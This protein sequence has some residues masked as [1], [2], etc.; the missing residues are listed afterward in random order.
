MSN[1][2]QRIEQLTPAQRELF[3]KRLAEKSSGIQEPIAVVGM[4]CR[5]PDADNV[6]QFWD[7]ICRGDHAVRE[8]PDDRFPVDK[9]YDPDYEV[10]G[11]VVS[12]W[13]C[14]RDDLGQFDPQFFGIAPREA[15]GMDPQQR[16]LLEVAWE[17]ME[18]ARI[19]PEELSK[20]PT[21]VFMGVSQVDYIKLASQF[22]N[23][24]DRIDAHTG[25]G[26]SL[27]ICAN[28]L[29]YAFNFSGPSAAIDTAC[30]SAMVALHQAV[31]SLRSKE[32][33][34]ALVGAANVC[35]TPDTMISLSRARMVSPTGQCRPFHE[36]ANGYVR[37]EG[38]GVV[39]LKRL[40]DAIEAGDRVLAILRHTAVNH[41]GRTSGITAPS[42]TAQQTVIQAALAGGGVAASDIDYIEAHGTGTPLGDPIEVEALGQV[43]RKRTPNDRPVYLTSVKANIGHLE[44]AAGI[45]GLIKT[46]LVLRSGT[47]PLQPNLDKLNPRIRTEGTRIQ[48]PTETVQVK[49][50]RTRRLAGV[51][52]F[53]FGGTNGHA[54]VESMTESEDSSTPV[55]SPSQTD[56]EPNRDQH[57]LTLSAKS[58]KSLKRLAASYCEHIRSANLEASG[59]RHLG[60]FCHA[61]AVSRT[62]HDRRATV[63]VQNREQLIAD[64]SKIAEGQ[65]GPNIHKGRVQFLGRGRYGFLFTG[66]GSQL[67]GMGRE[68]Y[69]AEPV[70]RETADRCEAVFQA[71]R[72]QSLL[73]VMF[74]QD[75]GS[76][77]DD[78]AIT[79]PAL[80]TLEISLAMLWKSWGIT[81]AVVL[82]HSVGEYAAA[83]LAGVFSIEDGLRLIAKRGELMGRLPS[84]G[85]MAVAFTDSDTATRLFT[86]LDGSIEIA[87]HNGPQNTT[88]SG[89]ADSIDAFVQRCNDDGISCQRL[90]VSHAFHSYRMDPMLHEFES[91][92]LDIDFAMP[93]IPLISN[94]T[95]EQVNEKV[96]TPTYWS[97]QIRSSVQFESGVATMAGEDL[98]AI[99]EM[100]P[101]PALVGMA[102]RCQPDWSV[103]AIASLRKGKPEI[104][105]LLDAVA[106]L[107]VAGGTLDWKAFDAA[108]N[109]KKIDL[110]IYPFDHQNYWLDD[111]GLTNE[112]LDDVYQR[113]IVHPLLGKSITVAESTVFQCRMTAVSHSSVTDHV[114]QGST[115]VPGSGYTEMGFAAANAL[116]GKGRHHVEDLTFQHALFLG[117]EAKTVQTIIS[118][119]NGTRYPFRIYSRPASAETGV[120]WELNATGTIVRGNDSETGNNEEPPQIDL[121]KVRRRKVRGRDH[122]EFYLIMAE[123][124][125]NYGPTYQ[126]MDGLTQTQDQ[127]IAPMRFHRDVVDQLNSFTIPPAVGDGA[128]HCAGGVVPAQMDG[129]FTPY[130]YLPTGIRSVKVFRPLAAGLANQPGKTGKSHDEGGVVAVAT[131]TS[132][133]DSESPE[134][135]TADVYLTDQNG[136]CLVQYLGVSLRRLSRATEENQRSDPHQWLYQWGWIDRDESLDESKSLS[137]LAKHDTVVVL[138]DQQGVGRRLAESLASLGTRTSLVTVGQAYRRLDSIKN[139]SSIQ[140]AEHTIKCFEVDAA[141]E[142]HFKQLIDDL[143]LSPRQPLKVIHAWTLDVTDPVDDDPANDGQREFT[144]S[145]HRSASS[146]L[147]LYRHLSAASL[148]IN[149]TVLLVTRGGQ[150]IDDQRPVAFLQQEMIG[151][152]RAAT[153]EFGGFN[154]RLVDLDPNASVEDSADVLRDELFLDSE[155]TQVAWRDGK[156]MGGRIK[157]IETLK[158]DDDSSVVPTG[159]PYHLTI[160]GD[161]TIEGLR[162]QPFRRSKPSGKE[163]EVQ[164]AATG[165][166]FS[167]VLKSLGLYP[168]ITDDVVPV[169]IECSAVVSAIGDQVD[170]L[171]VG[172]EVMGIVPH[173]FGSHCITTRHALVLKPDALDFEEA[174]TIPIAFMTAHHC[175]IDVA[176]LK[177]GER[178]LIHAGA[179]G[180]GLAAIQIAQ[181]IGAEVFATAGSDLKR[182]YLKSIGVDHVMDSRTVKFSDQIQTITQGSGVDVVLNSLPGD[183]IDHSLSSLAEYGRFV[184]IGKVDIYKNKM[185]GLLPFQRNLSY[186]AVDLDRMFRRRPSESQALLETVM[187]RFDDGTYDP[188]NMTVFDAEQ[189]VDAFRYMSRRQNI[190][191]VVVSM[192]PTDPTV[193]TETKDQ[194]TETREMKTMIRGEGSYLVTGGLGGLGRKI[195][196]WLASHGAGAVVLT[197][198]REPSSAVVSEINQWSVQFPATQFIT[199]TTDVSDPASIQT[200]IKRINEELPPLRGVIHAAGAV[201]NQFMT[202]MDMTTYRLNTNA[203]IEG[204]W[205][206]HRATLDQPL[207]F[208]VLFSSVSTIIGTI[209]QSAYGAANAFLDGLAHHRRRI[210]LPATTINWGPWADVGMAADSGSD[211]DS[212]GNLA[213][214]VR[215]ALDLMGELIANGTRQATVMIADWPKLI[216]SYEALRRTGVAPP[217]FDDFKLSKEVDENA[218]EEAKAFHA[219]LM[220]LTSKQRETELRTYLC[221][222]ISQ[223]MGLEPD[224]LDVNQ[225]LNTMG[226]DSLM[227]IELANKLQLTLQVALPMSIFIENPSVASLAKQSAIAIDGGVNDS[228]VTQAEL[229]DKA[230]VPKR[231]LETKTDDENG[232][233]NRNDARA[234]KTDS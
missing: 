162:Y 154:T 31:Q 124:N 219:K 145:R 16:M 70:F 144:E 114:V 225:S 41:G 122:S 203:K 83:C 23:F 151:V 135:V 172:D 37:G 204:G 12:K 200:T 66:Q 73:E 103:A 21:G 125:L 150:I 97:E 129:S 116:F 179:G 193:I 228:S 199:M 214:P 48:I 67:A 132:N 230:V 141:N 105:A 2:K 136:R 138:A 153:L 76:K 233:T 152:G 217:M 180:V 211:L 140:T 50:D 57:L 10:P 87:A 20:T 60:D 65:S 63:R 218:K 11:K 232:V 201:K 46:I 178:V 208:L 160:G 84:G 220:S 163:V 222:Q 174:A 22:D 142:Q 206:L 8:I 75:A 126:I 80:F 17:A 53:G 166:N 137:D 118:P 24:L 171:N 71:E 88:V 191:K 29:S 100:G 209:Q 52:S 36:D 45:A 194:G 164:V 156:R 108:W 123:R 9:L 175:L 81:P 101:T 127:A 134:S 182:D 90:S 197:S 59:D 26:N 72:G 210:G 207:D 155:E 159:V 51:S 62:H 89:D 202:E 102:K 113:N 4:A 85:A 7:L 13:A 38:A 131:R 55:S 212:R 77:I 74:D 148:G 79:Q 205:N 133:D 56:H 234:S 147:F 43:F 170:D 78:T 158:S 128:M 187:N 110:P 86:A 149:P 183:A 107:Y 143:K 39:V 58:S 185:I 186:T 61:A 49:N 226:L 176:R 68:L 30:S 161:E 40:S 112:R 1:L 224:D 6:D 94:V 227:A 181:S 168:G 99:I 5:F 91:Y 195:A 139:G 130:T 96:L 35:I 213:L 165:L 34:A 119:P 32:C 64:L 173:G 109:Y 33:D 184:E 223:I 231:L 98:D 42:G 190:G 167:D 92:A 121:D 28:R 198:R 44:I 104:N 93:T 177:P 157:R 54:I 25:T 229:A 192:A 215:P 3:K 18:H 111:D 146:T 216:R 106:D 169:G 19:P 27:S 14:L 15:R 188:C 196:P 189:V 117:D 82:G 120:G 69:E 47:V 115:L 95:G 221:N